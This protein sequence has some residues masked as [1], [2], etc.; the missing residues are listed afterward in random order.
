MWNSVRSDLR[1][2]STFRTA[3]VSA[4]NDHF[5]C[6]VLP[7]SFHN[8]HSG[9]LHADTPELICAAAPSD[10]ADGSQRG[11]ACTVL[12]VSVLEFSS[13]RS[14][15]RRDDSVHI[16]DHG[17]CH[18]VFLFPCKAKFIHSGRNDNQPYWESRCFPWGVR[19]GDSTSSD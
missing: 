16:S 12:P 11:A 5:V 1:N 6:S 4:G 3:S 7:F 15:N 10:S 18:H 2:E 9:V 13:Y 14:W 17:L 19:K 8:H